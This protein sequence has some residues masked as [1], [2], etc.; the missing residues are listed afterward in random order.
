[1][2]LVVEVT[3]LVEVTVLVMMA[4]LVEMAVMV[5]MVLVVKMTVLLE[6]TAMVV[7]VVFAILPGNLVF[8]LYAIHFVASR[9]PNHYLLTGEVS[10]ACKSIPSLIR[11]HRKIKT[12]GYDRSI[13][14]RPLKKKKKKLG[15]DRRMDVRTDRRIDGWMN[16]TSYINACTC[17]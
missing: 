13:V 1:M 9:K 3:M 4:V 10:F 16:S 2:V 17:S 5:M 6:M 7:M 14:T 8:Q 11:R 15:T 12:T